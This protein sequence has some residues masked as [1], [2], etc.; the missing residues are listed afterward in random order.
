MSA[1]LW[2]AL[3]GSFGS[4]AFAGVAIWMSVRALAMARQL[5]SA[6]DV[7]AREAKA[8]L[9]AEASLANVLEANKQLAF[10]HDRLAAL[11]QSR[12]AAIVKL[13]EAVANGI[14]K[15]PARARAL[16]RSLLSPPGVPNSGAAGDG[17]G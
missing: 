12:A 13:Q 15:S 9:V 1:T 14:E 8:R 6:I 7:S 11:A 17:K 10:E 4:V 2:V 5:A 3:G 16:L